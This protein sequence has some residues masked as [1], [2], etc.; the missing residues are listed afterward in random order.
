MKE[1]VEMLKFDKSLLRTFPIVIFI[2]FTT[3][4]FN[5]YNTKWGEVRCL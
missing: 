3:K 1:L 5:K 2:Y 4:V